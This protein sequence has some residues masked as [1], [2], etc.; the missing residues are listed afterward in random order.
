MLDRGAGAVVTTLGPRGAVVTDDNGTLTVASP[1]VDAADAVDT[2]GAGDA[3]AGVLAA[4]LA[5]GLP[6]REAAR[7]AAAA[8]SWAVR[9]AGTVASYPDAAQLATLVR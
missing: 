7:W 9:S 4:K 1:A 5:A 6:L 8:G 2:T 3:F